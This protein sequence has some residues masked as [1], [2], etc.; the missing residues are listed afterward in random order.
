MSKQTWEVR[1]QAPRTLLGKDASPPGK[2]GNKGKS[3]L[4]SVELGFYVLLCGVQ[5]FFTD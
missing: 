4:L 2:D 5:V 3:D 1:I